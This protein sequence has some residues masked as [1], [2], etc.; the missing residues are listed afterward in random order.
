MKRR[1]ARQH[2]HDFHGALGAGNSNLNHPFCLCLP[3]LLSSSLPPQSRDSRHANRQKIHPKSHSTKPFP[4]L[5]SLLIPLQL[6]LRP[7]WPFLLSYKSQLQGL[8]LAKFSP[9]FRQDESL[10]DNLHGNE[11]MMTTISLINYCLG[12]QDDCVSRAG[13]STVQML[14]HLILSVIGIISLLS[15]SSP[16]SLPPFSS[17]LLPPLTPSFFFFFFSFLLS[18]LLYHHSSPLA[19]G[20]KL[21]LQRCNTDFSSHIK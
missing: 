9:L 8:L 16:D 15:F 17:F 5:H 4:G 3:S 6:G 12:C 14:T 20:R 19:Q 11:L 7:S 1:K 13:L 21:Q 2:H 18:P 10:F